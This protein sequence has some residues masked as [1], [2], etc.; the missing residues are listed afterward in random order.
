MPLHHRVEIDTVVKK[1]IK[2]MRL[3]LS[4]VPLRRGRVLCFCF[5]P[6][7]LVF[8]SCMLSL[9]SCL[10]VTARSF[11][12]WDDKRQESKLS[13]TCSLITATNTLGHSRRCYLFLKI[14][15]N[16]LLIILNLWI[17]FTR[18]HC[19]PS[20]YAQRHTQRVTLQ[21]CQQ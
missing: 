5:P 2:I 3:T 16:K 8:T 17:S 18:G 21:N 12:V 4:C 1:F 11:P 13:L 14:V 20:S 7:F 19:I 9:Q 10:F 15:L 6:H